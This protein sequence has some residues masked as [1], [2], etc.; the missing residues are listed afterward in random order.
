MK[1]NYSISFESDNS[2]VTAVIRNAD[3]DF[4]NAFTAP[5]AVGAQEQSE[6]WIA[7]QRARGAT[8]RQIVVTV[9]TS[10]GDKI[11]ALLAIINAS[12]IVIRTETGL[13]ASV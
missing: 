9:D 7:A 1:M 11:R 12:E 5:T 8:R 6:K 2:S 3:G 10:D 4:V 13:P